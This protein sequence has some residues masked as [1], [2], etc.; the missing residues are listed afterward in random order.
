MPGE[1]PPGYPAPTVSLHTATSTMD[2]AERLAAL[3]WPPWTLV[4]AARQT[5]GRGRRGHRWH[6]PPGGLW[7]SLILPPGDPVAWQYVL[8]AATARALAELGAPVEV[9]WPNDIYARGRKLAG[10][11]VEC[12]GHCIGGVGVNA[13]NPP[14]TPRAIS[15]AELGVAPR[16]AELAARIAL[17]AAHTTPRAAVEEINRLLYRGPAWVSIDGTLLLCRPAAALP[18]G[19]LAHCPG[20]PRR[21]RMWEVERLYYP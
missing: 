3:G 8:G 7:M 17:N 12:S 20:G 16:L 18:D 11:I 10:V 13:Y 6:S 9:R 1:P 5:A 15:L 21:L 19:L 14:P 4:T 2:V